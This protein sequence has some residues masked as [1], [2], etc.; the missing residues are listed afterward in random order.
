MRSA[1]VSSG[2]YMCILFAIPILYYGIHT[3]LGPITTLGADLPLMTPELI[4]LLTAVLRW[5]QT[6]LLVLGLGWVIASAFSVE[7]VSYRGR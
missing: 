2:V 1:L 3:M 7:G 5:A 4:S 6:A